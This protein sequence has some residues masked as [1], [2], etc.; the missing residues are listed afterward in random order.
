MDDLNRL[1]DRL[2]S[3]ERREL[4]SL[5]EQFDTGWVPQEGT[6]TMA[7]NSKASVIGFGGAPGGGKTALM[8]GLTLAPWH[9]RVQIARLELDQ[10]K[11]IRQELIEI[12]LRRRNQKNISPNMTGDMYANEKVI[13]FV[14]LKDA[15]SESK[16]QGNAFDFKAFD[17]V[18]A[19]PEKLVKW[20]LTWNRSADKSVKVQT[21]FFT[22][23]N[24]G[25]VSSSWYFQ[26]YQARSRVKI[27]AADY[28]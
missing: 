14:G 26:F 9:K 11:S 15:R 2:N 17:E 8:C 1:F 5:I 19:I 21:L 6:Q 3:H 25:R 23:Y 10:T 27:N 18:T 28:C 13:S 24:G 12:L 20:S 7:Y 4:E 22:V 16:V